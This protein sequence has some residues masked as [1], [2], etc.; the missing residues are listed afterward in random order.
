[1]KVTSAE[2]VHSIDFHGYGGGDSEKAM[3]EGWTGR[4]AN[5][6]TSTTLVLSRTSGPGPVM[7][8]PLTNVRYFV[9]E[10]KSGG[11]RGKRT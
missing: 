1:M 8:V 9:V 7:H 5:P 11:A 4:I 2:F 3:P 6:E 10:A